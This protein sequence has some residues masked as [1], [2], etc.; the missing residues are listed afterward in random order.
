M[1]ENEALGFLLAGGIIFILIFVLIAVVIAIFYLLNLQNL[2]KSIKEENREVPP[3]NV[4][5]MLIPVFNLIY[6]FI[7]YPKISASVKKELESRG[8]EGDGSKNLGLA[9]AI[10]GAL[11][12]VPVVNSISGIVNLVIWIIWWSKTSGY[13]NQFR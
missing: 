2:M 9:L 4:W 6:A 7:L 5:L 8:L 3:S 10:T 12:I 11:G 13:K 1:S